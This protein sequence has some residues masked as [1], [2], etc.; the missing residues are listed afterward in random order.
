M[1]PRKKTKPR[2]Q[3]EVTKTDVRADLEEAIVVAEQLR[4]ENEAL[5]KQLASQDKTIKDLFE[6]FG[7]DSLRWVDDEGVK[8]GCTLVKGSTTMIDWPGLEEDLTT[9]QWQVLLDEPQPSKSKL[10]AAI[11]AGLIDPDTV[12]RHTDE[13][14]RAPFLRW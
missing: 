12:A 14:P 7:E 5:A 3:V 1:P 9:K 11:I 8:H 13:K 2:A 4:Q 6:A 10:E